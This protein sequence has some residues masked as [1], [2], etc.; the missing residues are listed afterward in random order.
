MHACVRACLSVCPSVRLSVCCFN[1]T[2]TSLIPA[3]ISVAYMKM[4]RIQHYYMRL[5]EGVNSS[6]P[7]S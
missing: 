7:E 5:Y 6:N 2:Y 3:I 4:I 1:E